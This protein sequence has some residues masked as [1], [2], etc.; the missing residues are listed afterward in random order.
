MAVGLFLPLSQSVVSLRGG[1]D[2]DG[3]LLGWHLQRFSPGFA[4]GL[5]A[6]IFNFVT[7]YALCGPGQA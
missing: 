2:A 5:C 3:H 4:A 6:F 1:G 7:F